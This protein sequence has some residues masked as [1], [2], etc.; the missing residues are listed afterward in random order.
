MH[1][2]RVLSLP[3]SAEKFSLA[4]SFNGKEKLTRELIL[5]EF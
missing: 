2:K 4:K 1:L 3:S 5:I